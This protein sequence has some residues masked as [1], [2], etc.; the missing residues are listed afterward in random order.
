M[1]D[2]RPRPAAG[3]PAGLILYDGVCV[4][5]SGW[6]RFVVARDPGGR[7]RFVPVQSRFGRDLAARFGIDPEAPETNAVLRDGRVHFKSD[8]VAAVLGDLPGWG[9]VRGLARLPRPLRDWAYDRVA[10]NRYRLFGRHA[11]CTL[12]P[13][14]LAARILTEA[15]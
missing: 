9:W 6:V 1:P 15:P 13:P 8:T 3:L 11:A 5:C 4:L 14:T 7:W 2:W 12:P 10:R